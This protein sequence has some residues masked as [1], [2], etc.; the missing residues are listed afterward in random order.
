MGLGSGIVSVVSWVTTVV[1]VPSLAPKLIYAMGVAKRT[2]QKDF[3]GA[4][5]SL[6]LGCFFFFFGFFRAAPAAYG[7]SQARC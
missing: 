3:R 1:Q 5:N 7:C 4:L 6:K 2:I